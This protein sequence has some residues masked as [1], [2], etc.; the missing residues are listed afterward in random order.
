M[1]FFLSAL[2]LMMIFEGLPCFC[3]PNL[4]KEFAQKIPGF[5]GGTLRT[6]GLIL[7]LVGLA[8]VYLGKEIA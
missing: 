7:M 5:T 1:S 3:F 2:G 4:V 6:L 8:V